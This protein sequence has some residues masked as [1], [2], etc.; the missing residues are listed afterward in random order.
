[1]KEKE[2]ET[3]SFDNEYKILSMAEYLGISTN[4]IQVLGNDLIYSLCSSGLVLGE[5]ITKITYHTD[6]GKNRTIDIEQ[7]LKKDKFKG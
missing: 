6:S 3:T 7:H 2:T 4:K 1:M 5:Q